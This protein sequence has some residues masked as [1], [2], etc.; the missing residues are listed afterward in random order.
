MKPSS[1]NW[2]RM[3][4]KCIIYFVLLVAIHF[5]LSGNLSVRN[6]LNTIPQDEQEALKL[7]FYELFNEN[8]FSYTLFGDKPMSLTGYFTTSL[9]YNGVPSDEDISFW[10]KWDLWKKYAHDFPTTKYLLIEEP[11]EK[12]GTKQIYF[13]NKKSFIKKVDK[14]IKLFQKDFGK[15]ITGSILLGNI[16]NNPKVLYLFDNKPG[17]LGVLLGYG[18]H[19]SFL[20]DK[21][22]KLSS[23]VYRKKLPETPV[24]IPD[25]SEGF[26]SLQEE[27]N[28][29][30]AVLTHFGDPGYSPLIIHSVHFV[31]DKKHPETI[32]LKQKY[33]TMRGNISATY[34]KG[35]F[36]EITL[37]KLTE[38]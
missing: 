37:S 32:A 38:E 21:R 10:N 27:F 36:L 14:N 1:V 6:V 31:A 25:P 12:N 17:L 8:N 2:N 4:S 30:F 20:F 7:L 5:H 13:I 15:N 24:K 3:T 16:E 11:R 28:S 35:D 18:K 33:R 34:A 26:S 23:F 29:Y 22:N 19:N 9:D